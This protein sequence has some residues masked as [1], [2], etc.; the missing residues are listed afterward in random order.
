MRLAVKSTQLNAASRV[1]SLFIGTIVRTKPA[2]RWGFTAE[3]YGWLSTPLNPYTWLGH[4]LLSLTSLG[5]E[6][7]MVKDKWA[8]LP[9]QFWIKDSEHTPCEICQNYQVE[10][11]Q[12][13]RTI[14][15][16]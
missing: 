3:A 9:R 7:L 16:F 10:E 2:K 15:L 4:N 12:P 6:A 13:L 11:E 8:N 14:P 5:A 1:A